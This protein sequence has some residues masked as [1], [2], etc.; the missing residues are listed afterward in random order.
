MA[1]KIALMHWKPCVKKRENVPT[2]WFPRDGCALGPVPVGEAI[3]ESVA[4]NSLEA[5]LSPC[6]LCLVLE[7]ERTGRVCIQDGKRERRT[8]NYQR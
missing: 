8:Q 5:V 4:T 6:T 7:G 2:S 3:H 1:D